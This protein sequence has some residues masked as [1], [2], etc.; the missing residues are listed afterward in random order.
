VTRSSK[1]SSGTVLTVSRFN[2]PIKPQG[3]PLKRFPD[4]IL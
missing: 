2:G 3:K 4:S 1:Q